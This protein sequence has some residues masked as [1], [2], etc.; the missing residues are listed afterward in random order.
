MQEHVQL[1]RSHALGSFDSLL[2]AIW[3]DRALLLWLGADANRKAAPTESFV[4]PLM[5]SFTLG[6]GNFADQDVQE[7]AR[8]FTGWFVLRDQLR[9]LPHEHDER[10][11]RVLGRQGNLTADDIV[12]IVLEQPATSRFIVRKLYRGLI[13]ET[14]EP[15]DALIAPLAESFAKDYNVSRIVETILRSNLFFSE[16]SYRR[17]VKCPI[18][19][20]VGIVNALEGMVST[21]QLAQAVADLGQ[22]LCHPPTVKG[23]TGGRY[24][25]N[26]ATLLG[27]SHLAL[28]MLR[29]GEPYGGKL[30]PW[31][32]AQRYGHATP[33][34]AARFLLDLFLQ[35]DLESSAREALLQDMQTPIETEPG[36]MLRRLAHAVVTLPEYHLA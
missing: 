19:F 35:S 27:R 5:E 9:Y 16:Q 7:A 32:I 12:Q 26:T 24:W 28:A 3:R 34:S 22:D 10:A 20:A 11:V 36:A 6:P 29:G 23:W 1:L 4:R 8:A 15:G 31:A 21:V 18:E 17:R 13:C 14:D 2:K 33:E 25:I 30:D